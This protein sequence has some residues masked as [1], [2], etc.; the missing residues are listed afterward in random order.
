MRI[1]HPYSKNKP[2][3]NQNRLLV[4]N[5]ENITSINSLLISS[6]KILI[7][8]FLYFFCLKTNG[9]TDV[10]SSS[11]IE[12]TKATEFSFNAGSNH[13]GLNASLYYYYRENVHFK[14]YAGYRNFN[15]KS[16]SENILETGLEIGFTVWEGDPR[17][18]NPFWGLFNFTPT[19]GTSIELVK[20]TSK[21]TLIDD[22][23]KHLFI[24]AGGI[25]EYS[26]N[27]RLGINLSFREFYAINGSKDK[28]G[29]WRYDLGIAL[30][31]YIFR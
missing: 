29:R 10:K 3:T 13:Y 23:P 20:A 15:Y 31:Y 8:K 12:E 5:R 7:I 24:N 21:T 26:L 17:G 27:E 6:I 2:Q 11:H 25:L 30:R 22:Y 28:L 19:L 4:L 1:L 18:R 14:L 9:Q 16:Y